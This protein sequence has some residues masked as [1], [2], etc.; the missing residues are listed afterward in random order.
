MQRSSDRYPGQGS[1][2]NDPA[3][4]V[5]WLVVGAKQLATPTGHERRGGEELARIR[6]LE[7]GALAIAGE[8]VVA[9]G[10][11]AELRARFVAR[12]EFDAHGGTLVPGF[13]D[14]HTHPVFFGTREDE[15][16]ARTRGASYVEI[17]AA[18]GGILSSVRGVRGASKAEL[19]D[20]L[21]E[22][23]ERFLALGTTTIE[24]KTGYGLS[25]A[26]ELKCLDVIAEANRR[27]PVELVPTFLGAH[28]FPPEFRDRRDEYVDALVEE[29]LPR[30]AESGQARFCDIF[31]ES[32]VFGLDAS[33]RI[34]TRAREL[35]FGLRLHVDQLT[36]LGGAELAAELGAASADHLEFV[37]QAGIEAPGSR[38]RRARS[39]PARAALPAGGAGGA[40]ASHD[41][42]RLG[43]GARDGLQS[44][45]LLC[46]EPA[47]GHDVGRVALL[48]ERRRVPD[49]GDL[50]CR[51]V[52]RAR[53]RA[54]VARGGQARGPLRAR[55]SQPRAPHLRVRAQSGSR[56]LRARPAGPRATSA[57]VKPSSHR[58]APWL[59]CVPNFSEGRD[60]AVLD[61]LVAAIA[62]VDGVRVLN[63]SRDADHNRSVV[64][65]A[66]P[67][68]TVVEGALAG[69]S[70]G[71]LRIDLRAH[72][73]VHPR[74]G[75][76]D[77]CPFVALPGAT[78]EHAVEAAHELGA[79]AAATLDLPIF[80][81]GDAALVPGGRELPELRRGGLARLRRRLEEEPDFGPDAG[82]RRLHPRGG[83]T[84]VGARPFL[85][86]FNIN[87]ESHD[88][89]LARA[90]AAKVRESGG[91]LPG[92]RA[93]GLELA[94]H[95]CVQVSMNLC[96]FRAT[97]LV[98]VFEEV[99]RLA[100][101]ARVSILESELIG[102]APAAALDAEVAA[103]VRLRGF[104]PARHVV[105]TVLDGPPQR[106]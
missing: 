23:L 26:D 60:P 44:R 28:D 19:L 92:V 102:L 22:R 70:E 68:E 73:G 63:A 4:T 42:G 33:R 1:T 13:V 99:E 58:D 52:A 80:Y 65:F 49:R 18:G 79:R 31:T 106:F 35:G 27:Q 66:G 7:R 38:R 82:P 9:I 8:R 17:A 64:T 71:L 101:E 39:L 93:L 76:I 103:R 14:A 3:Q 87:L 94:R 83:A 67:A 21:L 5:D 105:E 55:R 78:R 46:P 54:G 40:G 30:V 32:H 47:R 37:S 57:G 75:A 20:G 89:A 50:E 53:R 6:V 34:L 36:P 97:G 95:G 77:V 25:L 56:R 69:L 81:Y 62:T 51:R 43:S 91:G 15:F 45:Q 61:E 59:E 10:T 12:S 48:H 84:A 11:E 88:L 74:I 104:D 24:A 85:I 90:I 41:R 29:M 72:S 16:E 86:A 96:D 98:R 100:R 2:A